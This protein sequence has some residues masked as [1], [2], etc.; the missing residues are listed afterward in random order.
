M[1]ENYR[2]GIETAAEEMARLIRVAQVLE[3]EL[4]NIEDNNSQGCIVLS[5]DLIQRAHALEVRI[6][7]L[8]QLVYSSKESD[9]YVLPLRN[10][11]YMK[12]LIRTDYM[13]YLYEQLFWE[14]PEPPAISICESNLQDVVKQY[15]DPKY[16]EFDIDTLLGDFVTRVGSEHQHHGWKRGIAFAA[17]FF[18]EM[19]NPYYKDEK[20]SLR[21]FAWMAKR[22]IR[23]AG[24]DEP[25]SEDDD[26][27][28]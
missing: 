7:D 6:K 25:D 3:S 15:I 16:D 17:S 8:K 4:Q 20:S 9:D 12:D 1:S 26:D 27:P 18:E 28:E 19:K 10:S 5:K 2:E 13:S 14:C 22:P 23:F 24:E 21:D 11:E